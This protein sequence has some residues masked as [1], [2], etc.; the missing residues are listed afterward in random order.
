MKNPFKH[1]NIY[2]PYQIGEQPFKHFNIYVPYQIDK[3]PL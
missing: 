3:Q 2:V 1:S